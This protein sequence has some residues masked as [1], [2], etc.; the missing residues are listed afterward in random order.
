LDADIYEWRKDL[1]Q[2]NY[3][4]DQLAATG[5]PLIITARDASEG[6]RRPD[7][8]DDDRRKAYLENLPIATFIDIEMSTADRF[9]DVISQAGNAG[10]GI[11]LSWH[12]W[13][14]LHLPSFEGAMDALSKHG[15]NVLKVAVEVN[16]LD[17]LVRL[18]EG[19]KEIE[20][21]CR[22][23]H[24]RVAVMAMGKKW[25]RLS[26]L[27]FGLNGTALV[28]GHLGGDAVVEGQL[29]VLELRKFLDRLER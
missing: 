21:A 12:R 25:G 10:V 18:Y 24:R 27:M 13:G 14:M 16:S 3:V 28:Y 4:R 9:S 17:E 8:A 22:A 26:R 29:N 6:G 2:G 15:G 5:M 1:V 20:S 23:S 19:M 11:V 7:W